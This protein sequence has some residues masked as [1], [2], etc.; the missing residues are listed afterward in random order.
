M[1]LYVVTKPYRFKAKGAEMRK[2]GDEV[3]LKGEEEKFALKN[4]C[5]VDHPDA[6]EAEE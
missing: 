1:S 6:E 2:M 3:D 4:Q 5:V